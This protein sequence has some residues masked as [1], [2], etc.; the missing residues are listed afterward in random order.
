MELHGSSPS[1]MA[2]ERQDMAPPDGGL[3]LLKLH[4]WANSPISI[5]LFRSASLS[6]SRS[7]LM[8]LSRTNHALLVPLHALHSNSSNNGGGSLPSAPTPAPPQVS[9]PCSIS[10]SSFSTAGVGATSSSN[11]RRPLNSPLA[12]AT[13]SQFANFGFSFNQGQEFVGTTPAAGSGSV[14][15]KYYPSPS[16]ASQSTP[17]LTPSF[18]SRVSSS[19]IH[20]NPV[21]AAEPASATPYFT[22]SYT[23]WENSRSS[24][25][26]SPRRGQSSVSPDPGG[27]RLESPSLV[28]PH[29][30]GVDCFAWAC[31][32]DGYA[33]NRGTGTFRELLLVAGDE[34]IFIHCFCHH[35]EELKAATTSKIKSPISEKLRENEQSKGRWR[36]WGGPG[37][38]GLEAK[39]KGDYDDEIAK[40]QPDV[41]EKAS[42]GKCKLDFGESE[43]E[44]ELKDG[45]RGIGFQ[46]FA[47]DVELENDVDGLRFQFSKHHFWP[48]SA[49]VVSFCIA[50]DSPSFSNLIWFAKDGADG[51][52][53]QRNPSNPGDLEQAYCVSDILSGTSHSLVAL[54]ITKRLP[55]T[56]SVDGFKLPS[57]SQDEEVNK[58]GE[59]CKDYKVESSDKQRKRWRDCSDISVSIASVSDWGMKWISRINFDAADLVQTGLWADFELANELF[60]GL[61]DH[62]FLFLWAALSGQLVACIDVLQY[63]GLGFT[64]LQISQEDLITKSGTDEI[65]RGVGAQM[66]SRTRDGPSDSLDEQTKDA[67][68]YMGERVDEVSMISGVHNGRHQAQDDS[69]TSA[70][71][72]KHQFVQLAVTADCLLVAITDTKGLV[73]LVSMENY[74]TSCPLPSSQTLGSSCCDLRVFSSYEVAGS[75]IG[76]AKSC[77]LIP[78]HQ[79]LKGDSRNRVEMKSVSRS[80]TGA[81]SSSGSGIRG[82]SMGPSGLTS[83]AYVAQHTIAGVSASN[84]HLQPLRRVLLPVNPS[85]CFVGMA[86]NAYSVTRVA[87]SNGPAFTVVQNGVRVQGGP[88]DEAQ[89]GTDELPVGY[90]Q[91]SYG[92]DVLAFG[93]Q[94][95]LYI[96]S[97][98]SLHVVLPPLDS[99]VPQAVG[100]KG[101]WWLTERGCKK[102]LSKWD[103]MLPLDS[104]RPA[105]KQ[106]QTQVLDRFLA[107]NG[108]EEAECLCVEN[109]EPIQHPYLLEH[110][111]QSSYAIHMMSMVCCGKPFNIIDI[112][113]FSR[114]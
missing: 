51:G 44:S 64:G 105:I 39:A 20:G 78:D 19:Q 90:K 66:E 43:G 24:F 73:Y 86:L 108:L 36:N 106:W 88:L 32:G 9:S 17:Y 5:S 77:S 3:A 71:K 23:P 112:G 54:V 69:E 72:N 4:D 48:S 103:C 22:P 10:P 104:N 41:E 83:R 31:S 81:F 45:D 28:F 87:T 12:P 40:P 42:R 59:V 38:T 60:L 13:P 93:C 61:K 52:S 114:S 6:P 107:Y 16:P 111:G 34:G 21:V 46:S 109:G 2:E 8:L 98:T 65:Q 84:N 80:E 101:P 92:G 75:D 74:L 14:L 49:E 58:V 63:C 99:F 55:A 91:S 11:Q 47:I 27:G 102:G 56:M 15:P 76:G 79:M 1:A 100:S 25:S 110:L 33:A 85:G 29:L 57:K 30:S 89:L 94:G 53:E 62:R 95:S 35:G 67:S 7:R 26:S 37:R 113:V 50:K 96:V 70:E 68:E 97:A 18:V 82:L